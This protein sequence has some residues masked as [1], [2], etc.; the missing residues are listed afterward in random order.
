LNSNPKI[1]ILGST[2]MIG[3]G[4][5]KYLSTK[6]FDIIE[7][8]RSGFTNSTEN[9]VVKIDVTASSIFD[10]FNQFE[11]G[12]IFVNFIGVIRHKIENNM[13]SHH[14]ANQ[15]NSEFPHNLVKLA[16]DSDSRVIQIATDCV[17]SGK[18]G[19]Y[20]ESS[21]A[22]PYD[23]Y[24]FSKMQGETQAENLLTLR[25]SVIGHEVASN[26]ELLDWVLSQ[27]LNARIKGFN[28][29]IW[30][31]VTTLQFAKLI[32]S[33][34]LNSTYGSG[35]FH[36]VPGD[37]VSKYQLLNEI[38]RLGDRLDLTVEKFN[39]E[40]TINRTLATNFPLKNSEIWSKAG[41]SAPPSISM[42]LQEYFNWERSFSKGK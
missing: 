11:N 20:S 30:N 36:I 41:Y 1:V 13:A 23:Y 16:N 4:V 18:K 33:E 5:T 2:G 9:R 35:T 14:N 31:G 32:E 7:V 24:G 25:V 38:T 37:K 17:F 22:D 27:P 8:N 3:S 12:S 15:V 42:M 40:M 29:H 26:F 6:N 39:D 21:L 28:N 34:I 10:V 19:A